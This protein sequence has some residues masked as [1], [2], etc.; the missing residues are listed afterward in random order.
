MHKYD[1]RYLLY[2]RYASDTTGIVHKGL[3]PFARFPHEFKFVGAD[4]AL[5]EGGLLVHFTYQ[6]GD[7]HEPVAII[8]KHI[9]EAGIR[10]WTSFKMIKAHLVEV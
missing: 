3:I 1:P 7:V 5:K 9:E 10:S 8:N 2:R 4:K 6:G